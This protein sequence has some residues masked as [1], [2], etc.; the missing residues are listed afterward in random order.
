MKG[1]VAIGKDKL[2]SQH[3]T[4][5][6]ADLPSSLRPP[7]EQETGNEDL[8]L[9]TRAKAGDREAFAALVQR[10]GKA[11]LN[12]IDRMIRDRGMVEDLWQE[13]FVRAL[14]N[15]SSYEPRM[16]LDGS[17]P[18]FTS[19]LYRIAANLTLDELRRRGRWRLLSWDMFRPR[20]TNEP[21]DE[22]MYDPPADTPDAPAVLELREDILRI[23]RALDAL[24]PEWRMILVLR[25]FQDLPYEEIAEIL[26]V[27]IGT[28][29]SRL[30]RAR[31]QLRATLAKQTPRRAVA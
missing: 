26:K 15:L 27:P 14:E 20:R 13:T 3:T 22:E 21:D 23:R 25:E 16:Q 31:E 9:I 1:T 30:A 18:G 19:W 2:L 10:H 4:R 24:P 6:E 17:G 7:R 11:V 5:K 28:V 12:L 8:S 29:R